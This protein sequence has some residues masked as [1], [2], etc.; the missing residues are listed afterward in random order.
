MAVSATILDFFYRGGAD[1]LRYSVADRHAVQLSLAWFGVVWRGIEA[2]HQASCQCF[3]FL[4]LLLVVQHDVAPSSE[5][6]AIHTYRNRV[7]RRL[8]A[9]E[10]E[11]FT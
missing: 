10:L 11:L 8:M 1:W 3:C 6:P 5:E 9:T 4:L 7:H 2:K